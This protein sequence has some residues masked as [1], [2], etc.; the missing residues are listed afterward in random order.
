MVIFVNS[1]WFTSSVV[2]AALNKHER[3]AF[4]FITGTVLSVLLAVI[5]VPTWGLS[6]IAF[7]SLVMEIIMASYVITASLKILDERFASFFLVVI[8]PPYKLLK[9]IKWQTNKNHH[10]L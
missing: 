10:P 3:M 9:N 1:L 6:G 5:L 8:T 4:Y 2:P 7:A